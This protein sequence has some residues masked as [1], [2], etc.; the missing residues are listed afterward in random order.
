M[1]KEAEEKLGL[2]GTW[3]GTGAAEGAAQLI[4]NTCLALTETPCLLTNTA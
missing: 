1:L 3:L 2:E 4:K